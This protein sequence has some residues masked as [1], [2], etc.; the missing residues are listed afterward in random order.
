MAWSAVAGA[1]IDKVLEFEVFSRAK[2]GDF[3]TQS[4][5]KVVALKDPV[6]VKRLAAIAPATR[7]VLFDLDPVVLTRAA[8]SLS[9]SELTSFAGYLTGLSTPTRQRLLDHVAA[10]PSALQTLTRPA[11]A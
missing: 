7:D 6:A 4:L 8:R 10:D 11:R 2:P 5:D 1:R 3:T 9:E